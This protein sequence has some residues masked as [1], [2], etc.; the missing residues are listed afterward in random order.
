MGSNKA[1][2]PGNEQAALARAKEKDA[3]RVAVKDAR[4]AHFQDIVDK[5]IAIRDSLAASMQSRNA[6]SDRM[7]RAFEMIAVATLCKTLGA[8]AG[9]LIAQIFP[10]VAAVPAPALAPVVAPN[11]APVAPVAAPVVAPVPAVLPHPDANR[12]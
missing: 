7:S 1:G 12:M 3:V 11:A 6:N 2:Q 9:P 5:D 4:N 8:E 10:P